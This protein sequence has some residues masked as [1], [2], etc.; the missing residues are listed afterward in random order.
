[1]SAEPQ[2]STL[3]SLP[4][5]EDQLLMSLLQEGFDQGPGQPSPCK[6]QSNVICIC[7]MQMQLKNRRKQARE[8]RAGWG[9]HHQGS[10]LHTPPVRTEGSLDAEFPTV[11]A[12][13]H[14]ALD[15]AVQLFNTMLLP[16][17]GE[18]PAMIWRQPQLHLS[19]SCHSDSLLIPLGIQTSEAHLDY[20]SFE[21]KK[22]KSSS[23]WT[24]YF[25][26]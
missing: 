8:R 25:P 6:L 24:L 10:G 12:K 19:G 16:R 17:T 3:L 4:K 7:I 20:S 26:E 5:I 2:F 14:L 9:F 1:M 15:P 21:K 11:E 13:W 23:G 22:L 18:W